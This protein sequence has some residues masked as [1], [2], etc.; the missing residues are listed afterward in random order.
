MQRPEDADI[1]IL[2]PSRA[3]LGK[4]PLESGVHELAIVVIA[5]GG[6]RR[7]LLKADFDAALGW[8]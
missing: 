1:D 3:T 6:D 4:V 7:P 5:A 8:P 2:S